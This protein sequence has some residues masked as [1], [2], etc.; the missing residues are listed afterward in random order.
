M[1]AI[2]MLK[3][4]LAA[5]SSAPP[6]KEIYLDYVAKTRTTTKTQAGN[7]VGVKDTPILLLQETPSDT[8]QNQA[9]K[10]ELETRE[11]DLIAF[12]AMADVVPIGQALHVWIERLKPK[13]ITAKKL[14]YSL[15]NINLVAG[16][17]LQKDTDRGTG[18]W[19]TEMTA[20]VIYTYTL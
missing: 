20:A 9:Q 10:T 17:T 4:M 5:D 2:V 11:V 15:K 8:L 14:V 1:S 6:F 3:A 13:K 12:S 16:P 18:L 19:Y 7:N